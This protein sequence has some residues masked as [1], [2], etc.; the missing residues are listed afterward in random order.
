LKVRSERGF[1]L[2]FEI[3]GIV[4]VLAVL[5]FVWTRIH[6]KA[7]RPL[8]AVNTTKPS[9]N[10]Y[11]R[12]FSRGKC[13]GS[14]AVS[15]THL[16]LDLSDIGV[17]LPYGGMTEA[18]VLPI[19]HGYIYQ[20][21]P[22]AAS[23]TYPVYA[24]ADGYIVSVGHRSQHVGNSQS[25]RPTNDYQLY[26]EH[27]CT[28]YSYFDLLTSL[29]P[30]IASKIDT[31]K[32]FDTEYVRIH[33]RAGQL[34][35][36][37][38][39]QSVDFGVWNFEKPAAKFINPASYKGDEER[40]YLDDMFSH[41][42]D[43]LKAQLLTKDARIAEPRSGTVDYDVAGTLLGNWFQE[44]TGGFTGPASTHGETNPQYWNGHLAIAYDSLDPSQIR[45][46]IGNWGGKAT[47]FG[48]VDNK[49]DPKNV[50]VSSGLVKIEL[51]KFQN[52]NRT[53]G[54]RWDITSGPIAEPG[55][56]NSGAVQGTVLLQMLAANK[57][58]LEAFPGLSAD[59]VSGFTS[60]AK[61]YV[62]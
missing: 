55:A 9:D 60:A 45:F 19:S 29:S 1:A 3:A 33:V 61:M 17:I 57:L 26:I 39:G 5:G 54:G 30:D 51:Q 53:T 52:Y 12:Q 41:F 16:P 50:D 11:S 20:V 48:F 40:F 37:V 34:I 32:A 22:N 35:G 7:N 13:Q 18:H 59:K 14:G 47:Q 46:S 23:D 25:S 10:I 28:F 36:R 44:G 56:Q 42:T 43:N 21:N 6:D 15:F 31:S 4:I 49:P 2:F 38:G 24:I 62:R 27:S 8:Q 58:K